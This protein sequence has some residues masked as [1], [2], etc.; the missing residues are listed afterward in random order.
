MKL[1]NHKIQ[2]PKRCSN[3]GAFTLI[4]LLVVIGIIAIL[5]SMLMPAISRA[6]MRATRVQCVNN[7]RQM[8]LSLT[9]YA[10]DWEGY[11]PVRARRTNCWV[12]K[13]QPYYK[14]K[15][16]LR[17]GTDSF[18]EDGTNSTYLINGWY[19]YFESALQPAELARFRTYRYTQG[20]P[21]AQITKPSDTI[22][23][24]EKKKG[25]RH[26][27]MDFFQGNGNDVDQIDQNRHRT[28]DSGTSGG[29][30]FAFADGSVRYLLFG[31]SISPVNLWAVTEKWRSQGL[32]VP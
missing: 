21:E 5:A 4:E 28:G 24:G 1:C 20:M 6:K 2:I 14:D 19:D 7:M 31:R 27:H 17:C 8:G 32:A 9:M 18:V 12:I 25:S 13:L 11:F 22:A 23:F 15:K 3:R 29:S 16:L 30:N 26:V 10:S